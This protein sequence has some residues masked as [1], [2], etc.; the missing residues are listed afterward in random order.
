MLVDAGMVGWVGVVGEGPR[1]RMWSG[2]VDAPCPIVWIRAAFVSSVAGPV[3]GRLRTCKGAP[4][5]C[6]GPVSRYAV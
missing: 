4:A 3:D 6:E 1:D 5:R 2:A